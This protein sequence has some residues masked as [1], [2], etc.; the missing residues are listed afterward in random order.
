MISRPRSFRSLRAL[1]HQLPTGDETNQALRELSHDPN[2]R[3]VAIVGA[4]LLESALQ[5]ALTFKLKKIGTN[6]AGEIF[7]GDDAPFGS[8]SAKIKLARA[9]NLL[10]DPARHDLDCMREI[11]NA[12]AQTRRTKLTFETAEVEAVCKR[13]NFPI[14][15]DDTS[16]EK[17]MSRW[18]FLSG[19]IL[20]SRMLME[21]ATPG[22]HP[23][24]KKELSRSWR[25][26]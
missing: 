15:G 16:E 12:F 26:S 18:R 1:I 8:F 4:A 9:I 5:A 11:R 6:R 10:G 20:Y 22:N 14:F 13:I 25:H 24:S 7:R 2:D 3:T 23:F 17:E 19:C 21:M